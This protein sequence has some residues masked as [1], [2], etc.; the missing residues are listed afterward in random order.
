LAHRDR[1][2]RHFACLERALGA[3]ESF[4]H[5]KFVRRKLVRGK[6]VSG[7]QFSFTSGRLPKARFGSRCSV[8]GRDL[9]VE[10]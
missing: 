1:S 9:G 2:N 6:F 4:L 10:I 8:L 7:R 3:A 5:P